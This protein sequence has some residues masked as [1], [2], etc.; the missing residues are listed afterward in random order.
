ME[1]LKFLEQGFKV[2]A[3][4]LDLPSAQGPRSSKQVAKLDP[5]VSQGTTEAQR[6]KG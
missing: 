2:T 1:H 5:Q 3:P 4:S 6:R